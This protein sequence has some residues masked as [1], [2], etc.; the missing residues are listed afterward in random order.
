MGIVGVWVTVL[1]Y[2][3]TYTG[4]QHFQGNPN[5]GFLASLGYGPTAA[6][7]QAQQAQQQLNQLSIPSLIWDALNPAALLQNAIAHIFSGGHSV[8]T[9]N[10]ATV[11]ST[12]PPP[13]NAPGAMLV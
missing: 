6:Q 10:A 5:A 13:A 4:V 7:Q 2:A 1:G 11:S 3:L 12:T 9:T 8:P